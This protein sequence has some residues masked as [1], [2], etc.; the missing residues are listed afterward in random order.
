MKVLPTVFDAE[1][2]MKPIKTPDDRNVLYGPAG[3]LDMTAMQGKEV[4][5]GIALP[6]GMGQQ[7]L[8]RRLSHC[9][10]YW[11]RQPGNLV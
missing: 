6:A 11:S 9:Q 4:T 10:G 1:F 3:D 2:N 7:A 5:V 8:H